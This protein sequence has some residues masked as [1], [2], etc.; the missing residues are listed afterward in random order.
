T[1]LAGI[2]W[3]ICE[4]ALA[5]A[6]DKLDIAYTMS[7]MAICSLETLSKE[8]NNHFWFQLYLRKDRGF[9]KSLLERAKACGC[10]TIFVKADLPV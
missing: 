6:A 4:I 2:F 7:T 9:T 1:V 5:L 8:A 10:Q 3:P